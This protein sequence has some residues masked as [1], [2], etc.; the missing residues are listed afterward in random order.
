MTELIALSRVSARTTA[1]SSEATW[2][3]TCEVTARQLGLATAAQMVALGATDEWIEWAV[4][5]GRLTQERRGVYAIAGGPVPPYRKVMAAC[6]AAGPRA[7]ASHYSAGWLWG[8]PDVAPGAV[9]ITIFGPCSGRLPG[10]TVRR[11]RLDPAGLI[12]VRHDVPAVVPPLTVIHLASL[13]RKVLAE[14]VAHDLVK[15]NLTTYREI[16]QCLEHV[17]TRGRKGAR[18]LLAHCLRELEIEGHDDS[19]AARRFGRALLRASLPPFQT[20][21][22]V[23]AEGRVMLLDFAWPDHKVGLEYLG[24]DDHAW[25]HRI[26]RDAARRGRLTAIGWRVLDMTSEMSASDV[27]RWARAALAHSN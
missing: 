4:R 14:R 26:A 25:A 9:E 12:K 13:G 22:Q 17:G 3:A 10:V 2:S 23:V 21:Y 20:Q 8:V 24:Q 5:D 18:A 7:A 27:I 19:P 6:L 16:V 1:A 11:S 15:R